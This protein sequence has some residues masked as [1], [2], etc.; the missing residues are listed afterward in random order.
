MDEHL[1]GL[2]IAPEPGGN[3]DE[4][5]KFVRS[6]VAVN[7]ALRATEYVV[8]QFIIEG[9][10]LIVGS[11]GAGKSYAVATLALAATGALVLDTLEFP[12]PRHVIYISEDPAQIAEIALGAIKHHGANK[13]LIDSRFHI[14]PIS[15]LEPEK[16]DV[17]GDYAANNLF[18][19]QSDQTPPLIVLDTVSAAGS[20]RNENDNGEISTFLAR[21]RKNFKGYPTWLIHHTAKTNWATETGSFTARGGG[22]FEGNVQGIFNIYKNSAGDRIME[23]SKMKRRDQ[24]EIDQL[25]IDS[26]FHT[27]LVTTRTGQK[28]LKK[29][30]TV[31]PRFYDILE[32][33]YQEELARATLEADG[34]A[35]IAGWLYQ[36]VRDGES[37]S[38]Q[39]CWDWCKENNVDVTMKRQRALL[40]QLKAETS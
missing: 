32:R 39:K 8:D 28:Q 29:Y 21:V 14:F 4:I 3:E 27:T 17:V 24:G 7:S 25:M 10:I 11:P 22:A 18:A 33:Q 9:Q 15:S 19:P 13:S 30:L 31:K 6:R 12:Y 2:V 23:A 5:Q 36:R 26:E 16:L 1:P 37:A 40:N 20:L 35:R 34:K 38:H